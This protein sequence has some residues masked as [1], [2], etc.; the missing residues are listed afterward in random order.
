MDATARRSGITVG[1]VI[2]VVATLLVGWYVLRVWP[3]ASPT[4]AIVP[5]SPSGT[6]TVICQKEAGGAG[7]YAEAESGTTFTC[8]NGATPSFS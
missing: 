4:S 7:Y 1:V 8:N 5:S 3:G 2:G 6:V